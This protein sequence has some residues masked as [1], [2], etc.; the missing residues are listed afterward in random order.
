MRPP[1]SADPGEQRRRAR[2]RL[3]FVTPQNA[4]KV[5]RHD[6]YWSSAFW[7]LLLE[8]CRWR[9][10]TDPAAACALARH[11]PALVARIG[12]LAEASRRSGGARGGRR[13]EL[14]SS[15]VAQHSALVR[16]WS[17]LADC[18]R[19][20]G[21]LEAARTAL[22]RAVDAAR[23]A[24][25][26]QIVAAC[27]LTRQRAL[28]DLSAGSSAGASVALAELPGTLR[29][30]LA[31]DGSNDEIALAHAEGLLVLASLPRQF[32]VAASGAPERPALLCECAAFARPRH[33]L[34]SPIFDA[35]L[36]ALDRSLDG[37]RPAP[38]VLEASG[39][40]LR[41][42]RRQPFRRGEKLRRLRLSWAEGRVLSL[43][44]IGRLAERR[45]ERCQRGLGD[46]G[47]GEGRGEPGL[48]ALATL[49]L[50]LLDIGRDDR[51]TAS[52][53]LGDALGVL[54]G[55]G[56]EREVFEILR[57][58]RRASF[59]SLLVF[60]RRLGRRILPETSPAWLPS[61]TVAQD[62]AAWSTPSC[63]GVA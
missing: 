14:F 25:R 8:E 61:P 32:Q 30:A 60:R 55:T 45:L 16:S 7:A 10:L 58:A 54:Q 15:D 37:S 57:Q 4:S 40:W 36:D 47:P 43:L 35:A 28:F 52:K 9:R 38:G 63:G 39:R 23:T 29:E 27:E 49:D 17:V 20:A 62:G 13:P 2:R 3:R 59:D 24:R 33:R 26:V 5:L 12:E 48:Y 50:A 19:L 42:A 53:R 51:P 21:S 6:R 11:G 41:Q 18:E 1:S 22:S 34:G 46:L 31:R 44:G 56:A